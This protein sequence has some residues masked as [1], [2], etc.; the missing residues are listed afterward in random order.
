M[1]KRIKPLTANVGILG[2]GHKTYWPQFEGL[3]DEMKKKQQIFAEM[4]EKNGVEVFDFG[5]S[6]CAE[7]A[8][9]LVPE[10]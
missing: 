5:I 10:I 7:T 3:L 9:E 1:I 2:V 6:D 8:Y 4:V